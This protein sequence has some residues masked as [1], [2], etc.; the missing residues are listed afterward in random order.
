M[1]IH[2]NCH[3]ICVLGGKGGVGKS[4]FAANLAAATLM[5]LRT[6]VLLLDLDSKSAGDQNIITGLRPQKTMMDLNGFQSSLNPQTLK[7]FINKHQSGLHYIAAVTGPEQKLQLNADILQKQISMISQSFKFIIAD[8]GNEVGPE[9][10]AMIEGC[11]ALIMVTTPEV[12]TVNQSRRAIHDLMTQTVPADLIQ[13]VI[14][15]A[16]RSGLD[17]RAVSQ[18]LRRPVVGIIP[19]DDQTTYNALQNSTPFVF[20]SNNSPIS[21]AYHDVVR[22]LTGG[23]LQKLKA[24]SR[25]QN[26]SGKAADSAAGVPQVG[27]SAS[28]PAAGANTSLDAHT[29]LKMQIH[30]E[31][32]KEMDLKKDLSQTK[33]DPVKAKELR[34][35]TLRTISMLTDKM[36]QGLSRDQRSATIKEVLDEALGLGPLERLL[37]DPT[38]TE[39]MVNG[40][41]MIY[42]EKSGKLQLSPVTF[43]SN[44]QLRNVIE[45]IVTPLGRRIDEKTPY[46]DARL[47][48]GSRV[49]A[50]IE[51]L[52]IDGPAVT[53]RKFPQDRIVADDYVTRFGSMTQAMVDFLRICVEQGLNIV[54]SGGTG[55]GKTTLLN[56]MSTFIPAKERIIT[57]EDA[58]ELQLKQEHVVRLETRPANMEGSGE[59]SI[60]DLIRNSLRMR[61]DRI[62]VGECRDGAALDMLSAMNTGH[63]GS[64]TTVH[65]NAP[66]EAV[67]R[68]ETLCM[69]AG[70]ELPAR[71]IREQIA[72]AVNLIV[73]ISRLSDGSR[74]ILSITEVVGMQ[75]E[76][77]TLQE[78]FR[79][80]EEGF[81]KNRKIIGQFQA[82]G[83]IPTFIEKFEQRGV[84]IPRN[85]FTTNNSAPQSASKQSGTPSAARP[86]RIGAKASSTTSQGVT[87]TRPIAGI[88]KASGG[89][90]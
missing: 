13:I 49:N 25:P 27:G 88:K 82:M 15:K 90:E 38:V 26:L 32:I 28:S 57:V 46:V 12:L 8:L 83:M 42:I 86:Q 23:T 4:V 9:Q 48:D 40:A 10:L 59:I 7:Q 20:S 55:S 22:K 45:R 17:P 33:D 6:S 78:I 3:L 2:Q 60:R 39:I 71:A 79:F 76:Q 1:S 41:K 34:D 52:S 56:V 58:A 68:L 44:Q 72:S 43:T 14:N 69:M 31:L 64:M 5:E 84:K 18:S 65:A 53:I 30:S 77:V 37:E 29:L 19:Q 47:A 75:G 87:R 61:P 67:S 36:G 51:P 11:S 66:R 89:D 63:D 35:K 21:N 73:Q 74:K 62:V 85:L 80:K 81:D 70:M 16:S 54:I 24:L 50:V